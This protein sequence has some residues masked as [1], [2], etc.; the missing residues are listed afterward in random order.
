VRGLEEPRS[1]HRPELPGG[2]L[3]PH[4]IAG[5]RLPGVLQ[6]QAFGR[7][8][9]G[10]LPSRQRLLTVHPPVPEAGVAQDF[11]FHDFFYN[12]VTG[13]G[14]VETNSGNNLVDL[15]SGNEITS[16]GLSY[17]VTVP[18]E[19]VVLLQAGRLVFDEAGEVVFEAGPHQV[20]G[21]EF[22]KLCEAL[23]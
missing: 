8:P 2:G 9:Q 13:E 18:G 23:A 4:L 7:E 6:G 5:K 17:H 16:V 14:F 10:G 11:Q 20:R 15:P 19:G 21:G 12:S 22:D 3:Y 1:R